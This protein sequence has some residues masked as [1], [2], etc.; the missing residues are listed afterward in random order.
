MSNNA[1]QPESY[2]PN[3]WTYM[4]MHAYVS[5]NNVHLIQFAEPF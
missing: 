1:L 2:L 3:Q 5:I 4:H